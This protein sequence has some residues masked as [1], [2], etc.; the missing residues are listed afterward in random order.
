V[1]VPAGGGNPID[2]VPPYLIAGDL[3]GCAT[4]LHSGFIRLGA[5]VAG[6]HVR[7]ALSTPR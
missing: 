5:G 3:Q 4:T 6:M 2:T 1:A 7:A